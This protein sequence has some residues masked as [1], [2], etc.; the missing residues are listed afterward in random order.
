MRKPYHFIPRSFWL[1]AIFGSVVLLAVVCNLPEAGERI[2]YQVR[3]GMVESTHVAARQ[4]AT[5]VDQLFEKLAER[6]APHMPPL[7]PPSSGVA[8]H[9]EVLGGALIAI[10][11]RHAHHWIR[12]WLAA[13]RTNGAK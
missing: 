12:G 4:T 2:G 8:D 11:Y 7:Q 13:R 3:Q 5:I 10:L 1:L 9:W 6:L